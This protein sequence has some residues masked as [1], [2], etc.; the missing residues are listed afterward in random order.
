MGYLNLRFQYS[1]DYVPCHSP[2]LLNNLLV[3]E[4]LLQSVVYTLK[5]LPLLR[6]LSF[7]VSIIIY[8]VSIVYSCFLWASPSTIK[9]NFF[10]E[11][12]LMLFFSPPIDFFIAINGSPPPRAHCLY[13]A[14]YVVCQLTC[15]HTEF[16]FFLN[17][18]G[19]LPQFEDCWTQW[20]VSGQQQLLSK[21]T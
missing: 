17:S 12:R 15:K 7:N 11:G 20:Q 2:F 5:C 13:V 14:K 4:A 1:Q 21:T 3:R 16:F 18:Q 19:K 8:L 6:S 9:K 10:F